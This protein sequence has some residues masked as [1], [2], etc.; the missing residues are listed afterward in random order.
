MEGFSKIYYR[1]KEVK[2][3]TRN[4]NYCVYVRSRRFWWQF[5]LPK[6]KYFKFADFWEEM[7]FKSQ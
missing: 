2:R 1:G 7:E 6:P 3:D 5:W 4:P